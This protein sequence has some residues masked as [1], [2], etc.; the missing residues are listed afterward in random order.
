ML[1]NDDSD[2]KNAIDLYKA[3]FGIQYRKNTGIGKT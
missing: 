3:P 1:C 2:I